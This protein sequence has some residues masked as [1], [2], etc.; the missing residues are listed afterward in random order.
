VQDTRTP[1]RVYNMTREDIRAASDV[2]AGMLQ[3]NSQVIYALIDPGATHSFVASRIVEKLGKCLNKVDKGFII[4]TPLGETVNIDCVYKEIRVSINGLEMRVYLLPLELYDFEVILGMDWLGK[5]KAQIDCFAKTVTL[6]GL[7][8]RRAIFKGERKIIPNCIISAMRARKLVQRGCEAYLAY[9]KD[10]EKESELLADIPIIKEFPDVFREELPG[11]P[12]EREVE[13]SIDIIPG[14]APIAQSP[15]RMAPAELA[16]L[17]IQL[18]ELLEKGFIRPS[19]SPWGAPVLFVKK[20]DGTLRLSIDYR[21]LN[22]VTVKNK[23]LLP[24]IDDLFDQLKGARV[25]SKID[26][27]SGYYQLRIKELDVPKTAF[28]TRYGHYEFLVM[29]FGLT[30]APTVFMDL[31]NRVFRPYLDSFVVIFIDDILVYSSSDQEH[32]Q[33]LGL[34]LQTLREHR[35]YA[36]LSKCEFWLKEVTFLGHVISVDGILVDSRKVEVVLK[37]ERPTN[38]TEIRSFL[39]LAGYHRRFIEGFSTIA[40]PMTR[41]TRKGTKWEWT[42]ECEESFQKLK[43]KLTTTPVL[44]L[45]SGTGGFVVYSD[46]SKRGLG[47]VLMQHGKVIAYASRQL[48]PHEFNYPVHDLELAAIVFALRVWRHYLYGSQVQIFIDHKSLRYLMTQKELNMR[49]RRWVELIKDYDCVIDYHPG[50]AN[51]VADALSRKN[52]ALVMDS[53]ECD[54]KELIELGKINAKIEVGPGDSLLA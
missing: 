28:R 16:E 45:P 7:D 48:K 12:P 29:P 53:D 1:G 2:V 38:V 17:K 9:V 41:L 35:L 43:Q 21:Q 4:S 40:I 54:N 10:R 6:Q 46:A 30:N 33:H 19:S 34:I 26:L 20:K 44:V 15:Y 25:F 5:Y 8:G 50:K 24:R 37:W 51:V 39:G 47:C 27:R 42:R 49:Q 22:K 18:Q 52:K 23:Y 13:V 36:K 11:L 14:S 32:E 3:V 31:M